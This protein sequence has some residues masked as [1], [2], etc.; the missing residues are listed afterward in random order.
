MQ[1]EYGK[2]IAAESR[3]DIAAAHDR[4]QALTDHKQ[5]FISRTVAMDVVDLLKAIEV[6]YKDAV[7]GAGARWRGGEATAALS[8]SSYWRRLGSPVRPS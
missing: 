5:R 3:H 4:A 8:A 6:E 7:C 1:R 2:L